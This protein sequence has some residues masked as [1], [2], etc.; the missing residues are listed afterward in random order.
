MKQL[1]LVMLANKNTRNAHLLC[2]PSNHVARGVPTQDA[3]LRT[4]LW[5]TV[6]KE[7]LSGNGLHNPKLA[8][9]NDSRQLAWCPQVLTCPP[10]LHDQGEVIIWPMKDGNGKRTFELGPIVTR[11]IQTL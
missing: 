5:S 7:F 1:M 11:G 3:L 6:M 9:G 4:S 10:P 8:E 2:K